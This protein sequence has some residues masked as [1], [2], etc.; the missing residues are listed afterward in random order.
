MPPSLR[1]VTGIVNF[2]ERV[3]QDVAIGSSFFTCIFAIKT[4]FFLEFL[5][6]SVD[7]FVEQPWC[8]V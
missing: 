1:E 7:E 2:P 6:F 4:G 3:F 5:E 8:L